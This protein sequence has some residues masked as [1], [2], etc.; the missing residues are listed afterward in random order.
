[1]L[2]AT[3]SRLGQCGSNRVR[4]GSGMG[5]NWVM[6]AARVMSVGHVGHEGHVGHWACEKCKNGFRGYW[7]L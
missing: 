3:V 2:S 1:M 6:W 4:N 7:F 5:Q